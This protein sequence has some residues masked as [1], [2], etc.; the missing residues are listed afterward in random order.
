M[1]I[2]LI[3]TVESTAVTLK[4]MI[5]A[6]H[7][8]VAVVG[9]DQSLA[10][11]HGDF[12]DMEPLAATAGAEFIPVR[13]VN[14]PE[15]VER[16]TALAPDWLVVVGWSQIVQAPLLAAAKVGTVGY[17]PSPLPELRGR[18]VLAWTILLCRTSTGGT[19]FTLEPTVDSGRILAQRL[20][21][22][23]RRETLRT[24]IDK[25]LHALAEMWSTLLPRMAARD[26][27]GVVQDES[28]SS[29]CGKRTADDGRIDW[30][31][32]ADDVDRLV[33]SVSEPYPGAFAERAG[34]RLVV[35]EAEP[36]TGS[37]HYGPPGQIL[38]L[39]GTRMLVACRL[40]ESL[41]IHR[42][43]WA[44]PCEARPLRVGQRLSS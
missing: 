31:A 2:V 32:P 42:W 24:L 20:F 40:G 19:L 8:P 18:A 39:D 34:D 21:D 41:L 10:D 27:S 25:H 5:G 23:D 3:G 28:R 38:T 30:N 44:S 11:R 17:H 43:N 14:A 35:W 6:G 26:I 1:R 29:H 22:L 16:I 37:P 7:V 36:W 4:T 15:V 13:S 33:R 12:V 9:L